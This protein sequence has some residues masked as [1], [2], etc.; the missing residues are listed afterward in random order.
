MRTGGW[1][2][3]GWGMAFI[4]CILRNR[5]RIRLIVVWLRL[6]MLSS[7]CAW[8]GGSEG[9]RARG[10]RWQGTGTEGM[11]IQ[12]QTLQIQI[13]ALQ[14]QIQTQVQSQIQMQ[15]RDRYKYRHKYAY[16]T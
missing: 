2:D 6:G 15:H 7:G 3:G 5:H 16:D 4:P 1:G 8:P 14:I 12:I 11:Q 10:G 13:H 9:R